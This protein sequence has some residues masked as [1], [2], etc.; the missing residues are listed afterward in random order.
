MERKIKAVISMLNSKYIHSSLAPWCLAAG[1]DAYCDEGVIAEVVEGTINE[2]ISDVAARVVAHEPQVI[3]FCCYIWNISQTMELIRL[4]KEQFPRLLIVLGGPEVSYNAR[5]IL[6]RDKLVDYVI[7]GEG[8]APF[9][10]LLNAL[11]HGSPVTGLPGLCY[12]EAGAIIVSE[13]YIGTEEP[14]SPYTGRYLEALKGRIAYLET[15][16]GCPYSCAFCLSGR[17]GSSR[18][19]DIERAKAEILLLANSGA[20]TVKLVDRTFNA[21]RKRAYELFDFIITNHGGAIPRGVCFHFEIAGDILDE[22]TIGLLSTAPVGAIQLEIGIQSFN[23]ETLEAVNRKTDVARLKHNIARLIANANMHIHID[24]IA[25][26]PLEDW[27]SFRDSFNTAWS[28]APNMLQLGFLKL[29]HGSPMREKPDDFPC[30]YSKE[31]PYEVTKTPWMPGDELVRLHA[32]EGALERIYNSGRF[33]RT[34]DY[35]LQQSNA[36]PFDLLYQFGMFSVEHGLTNI[37]LD[38]YTKLIYGYFGGQKNIEKLK[39][40]DVLVCDRLATDSSGVLPQFLQIKDPM[41]KR[42]KA[43]LNGR[44]SFQRPD[45]VKRGIALLYSEDC[46]VYADYEHKNPIT[47]EYPLIK[48]WFR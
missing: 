41:L 13:P 9:A 17:C 14:P 48:Y 22:E 35:I 20:Q 43:E 32:V 39:L 46:A 3:G 6:S 44:A 40:R 16:R 26:L 47:G 45:G 1:V 31:P 27:T 2:K 18:F 8:E 19:Y 30:E 4:I 7:A 38:E 21:N 25:G 12:R 28:L 37:T 11:L 15:S 10:L 33:K 34:L 36:A 23:A 5:A 29:L 42:V 24:L